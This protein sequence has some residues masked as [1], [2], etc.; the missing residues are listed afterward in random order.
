MQHTSTTYQDLLPLSEMVVHDRIL[1]KLDLIGTVSVYGSPYF[2]VYR[3]YNNVHEMIVVDY[4][5]DVYLQKD[6]TF[7]ESIRRILCLSH[8]QM[9]DLRVVSAFSFKHQAPPPTMIHRIP[10][11]EWS[12]I[13]EMWFGVDVCVEGILTDF[14]RRFTPSSSPPAPPAPPTPPQPPTP[15]SQTPYPTPS[16]G[17]TI[18][19][20][21]PL[22]PSDEE[23]IRLLIELQASTNNPAVLPEDPVELSA[24]PPL[25]LTEPIKASKRTW[26]VKK[27]NSPESPPAS[28]RLRPTTHFMVLRNGRELRRKIS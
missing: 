26:S 18:P 15:P 28:P 8:E 4:N 1:Q 6:L 2:T 12:A 22:H 23:L 14:H 25:D 10:D 16:M 3:R 27:E 17:P 5:G 19:Q 20:D 13:Q 21:I 11:M 7:T 24:P 9:A